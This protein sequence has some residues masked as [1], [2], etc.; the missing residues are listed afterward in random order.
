MIYGIFFLI[1]IGI[2]NLRK[3]W[4]LS[5]FRFKCKLA[6][7]HFYYGKQR[8]WAWESPLHPLRPED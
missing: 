8:D 2:D 1:Y 3:L 4:I 6:W 5:D 7:I